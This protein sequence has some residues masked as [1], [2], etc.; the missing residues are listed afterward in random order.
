MPDVKLI[1]VTGLSASVK[2]NC[3]GWLL[4]TRETRLSERRTFPAA[5]SGVVPELEP[6]PEDDEPEELPL[7]R[8]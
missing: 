2:L 3:I 5:E 8:V 6:P 4:R 1:E 7:P